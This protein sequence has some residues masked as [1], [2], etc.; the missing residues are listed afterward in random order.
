MADS[1]HYS[2]PTT[3]DPL[4]TKQAV[5]L[6]L[7]FDASG[8][9]GPTAATAEALARK[10][11]RGAVPV[12]MDSIIYLATYSENESLRFKAAQYLVDRVLGRISDTPMFNTIDED[13]PL[14]QL[15]KAATGTSHAN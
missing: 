13:D 14:T 1:N 9:E 4:G 5:D 11:A 8:E 3:W 2:S 12:A 7:N 10:K 15:V 6:E